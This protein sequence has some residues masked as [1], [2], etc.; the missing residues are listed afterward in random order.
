MSMSSE[1]KKKKL[2][3]PHFLSKIQ[4][5]NNYNLL[6]FRFKKKAMHTYCIYI[7]TFSCYHYYW[8]FSQSSFALLLVASYGCS[9][10]C[11]NVSSTAGLLVDIQIFYIDEKLLFSSSCRWNTDGGTRRV[12]VLLCFLFGVAQGVGAGLRVTVMQTMPRSSV[13]PKCSCCISAVGESRGG[14]LPLWGKSCRDIL[15][16]Q[17]VL[18]RE[19][20]LFKAFKVSAQKTCLLV[21]S[22]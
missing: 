21:A 4:T 19:R 20:D 11:G 5:S 18:G 3:F 6:S 12:W 16:Q 13:L 1:G 8:L 15:L 17:S 9:A 14:L 10:A 2:H 22:L 7:C